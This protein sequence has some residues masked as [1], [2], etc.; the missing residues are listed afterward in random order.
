MNSNKE[1]LNFFAK[2]IETETGI[3]Y[4]DHNYFQLQD[5]L[6]K[7]VKSF[8][9]VS[10]QELMDK[11]KQ[12]TQLEL[13]QSLID[14]ATNNETSFFRDK[15]FFDCLENYILPDLAKKKNLFDLKIWS[16]ASSTGQE[17]YGLMM[18]LSELGEK[19]KTPVPKIY[20]TDISN[21]VLEKAKLGIYTEL[22]VGRGL[23]EY[24]RRKYFLQD[25]SKNWI[26]RSEIRE[27]VD[28][29]FQNLL[30]P[31]LV[32]NKFDLI[33]CRNVLIYQKIE[34][35]KDIIKRLA[36]V[37]N[38]EGLLLLGAGESL[39]G[40]SNDFEQRLVDGVAIYSLKKTFKAIA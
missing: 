8:G 32:P 10:T 13:R 12:A 16:V 20:A 11:V 3:I 19:I 29:R 2:L 40:L 22:E 39:L 26:L 21:R 4:E 25:D 17:P 15:R 36:A 1:I 18:L 7:L 27:K 31:L 24:Y 37:L 23:A 34:S 14:L 38:P 6:E 5:R 9:L 30:K 35:K 33:L 28:F